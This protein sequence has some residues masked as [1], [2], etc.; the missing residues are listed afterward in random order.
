M[1]FPT[2][3]QLIALHDQWEPE[4][5][6]KEPSYRHA[7][8]VICGHAVNRMWHLWLNHESAVTG[9]LV[10]KE[11]HMCWL[12]MAKEFGEYPEGISE[13]DVITR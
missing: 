11:L 5:S 1:A 12:C 3:E 7:T 10:T 13:S 9:R 4:C 2:Q 8:C 6:Q